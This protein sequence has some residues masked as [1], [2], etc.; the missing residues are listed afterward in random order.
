M[1]PEDQSSPQQILIPTVIEQ[2]NYGER[3]Y[4]IYSRLLKDRIIFLGS[5]INRETANLVVA[6]LLFLEQQDAKADI[7]MY[8]NSPGGSVPAGMAIFDT[9]NYVK[10]DVHTICVGQAA[11][12]GAILL[13]NGAPKKRSI[14]PHA[15]VMIHQPWA[16][17]ITGQVTDIEITTKE[18]LKIKQLLN[19]ILSQK[20]GQSLKVLEN[21]VERDYWMDAQEAMKYGLVDAVLKERP[22]IKTSA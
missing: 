15:K 12:M 2:T 16:D 13:A 6:Q 7:Y 10:S 14:L 20:T 18:L 3:V 11:S 1:K 17:G 9:M 22:T 21:Q 8:I 5:S 19:R 4:D